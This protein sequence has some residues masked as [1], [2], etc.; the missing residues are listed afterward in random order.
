MKNFK[1]T[2]FFFT[3]SFVFLVCNS[4]VSKQDGGGI[5]DHQKI[6]V[7]PS[8]LLKA[9]PFGFDEVRLMEGNLKRSQD[10]N[11]KFL[12][13]LD[14]NRLVALFRQE[15]GLPKV[16][17]A[18][19]GWESNE[20]PGVACGFY[21]SGCSMLYA[22]TGDTR[23]LDRI[24]RVLD[25]LEECQ[26]ANTNG[27]LLATRNGKRIFS[28]IEQGNLRFHD[29]W[30]ING[31][32]E[33]YYAMEKLLSGLRD[34]WR[35][36][37]RPKALTIETKLGRWLL[38]HCSIF[39]DDYLQ[40]IMACE[41]GGIN[42]VLS[43]LYVDTGDK[44]FQDLSKR[45]W[46]RAVLDPLSKGEDI[47]PGLHANTQ[48][49]KII[50][51]AASY[52]Y[53]GDERERRVAEFFWDRVVHS[54]TYVTGGNSLNEHFGPPGKLNDRLEGNTTESCNSFNMLRLTRLL[55]FIEPKVEYAEY[56]ERTL[57]NH[58]LAHQNPVDG[59]VCYFLQ[60][61]SGST[62]NFDPAYDSFS[63]C[64]CSS[65][66]SHARHT[67]FIYMKDKQGLYVNFYAA[68]ELNWKQ[69]GIKVVQQT[70]FPQKNT[71]RFIFTCQQPS[72]CIVR[73]RHPVWSPQMKIL[74][75]G[76]NQESGNPDEYVSINNQ[77]KTG[78]EI[79][80]EFTTPLRLETMPDNPK[81]VAFFKGPIL[82]AGDVGPASKRRLHSRLDIP[83][84]LPTEG[85]VESWFTPVADKPLEFKTREALSLSEITLR[86]F[87]EIYDRRYIIY[88]DIGTP[89]EARWRA[90]AL[91]KL[92]ELETSIED[93]TIDKIKIGEPDS[94]R[95][96][97]LESENSNNG[98]NAETGVRW[99]DSS[100]WFSYRMTVK[101]DRPHELICIWW[102]S[103]VG[104]MFDIFVDGRRIAMV[105]HDRLYPGE[106]FTMAYP[107]PI[108]LTVGKKQVSV[109]F[110]A[111]TNSVAGGLMD[112]L[113]VAERK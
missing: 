26:N 39:S 75:N 74:V 72:E 25:A 51:L 113:R 18:Y 81:R 106:L 87:Y 73:L 15:S 90:A 104:R 103:D 48:F 69:R 107:I 77:W 105:H 30:K 17:D 95:A 67:D 84:L 3:V 54:Q 101:P 16:A 82:L 8:V 79:A 66:E 61:K 57:Y 99:R 59:R 37:G 108:E 9:E 91:Q 70:L 55:A 102:G 19:P 94:E 42:W 31:E 96:H 56:Y 97:N 40:R 4:G 47:L 29:G 50:G 68:S 22:S 33:P 44:A 28:E 111:H 27:Y 100:K 7:K 35:I 93:R 65:M 2:S 20:L 86:P 34:A 89:E 98:I 71:V 43:D 10:L 6:Y 92:S 46:H 109:K 32:C 63:C 11:A 21:L 41:F 12:L 1:L 53:T 36:A 64:V 49:P 62:K 85:P 24:D 83:I 52:P 5:D 58:I 80:V 38:R 23:F 14:I 60:L 88:W 76:K 112:I 78:D 110:Q 13:S 45:W